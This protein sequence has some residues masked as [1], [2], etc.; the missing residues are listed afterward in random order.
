MVEIALCL[1]IIGF[2]LVAIIGVLPMGLNVQKE[3]REETIINQD[4]VVWIDALRAGGTNQFGVAENLT[5][6]VDRVVWQRYFYASSNAP[7]AGAVPGYPKQFDKP[8]FS[9]YEILGILGTPHMQLAAAPNPDGAY[10]S[11][12]VYAYVRAMSGVAADLP[13]QDNRDIQDNAF[14]YKLIVQ[15]TPVGSHDANYANI[16]TNQSD[17][18]LR[19]NLRD[20][21]LL[22]RWPLR[23][24][25]QQA[26]QPDPAVGIGRLVYRT[27]VSGHVTLVNQNVQGQPVDLSYLQSRD[28]QR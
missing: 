15:S 4:A 5:N 22:F 11:N 2:A 19:E 26:S 25:V 6:Y 20:V 27:Q 9:G 17:H 28:Y 7:T 14:S 1:A 12:Y 18:T 13:P 8:F 10:F 23:S 3:N 16:L 24:S 21:R